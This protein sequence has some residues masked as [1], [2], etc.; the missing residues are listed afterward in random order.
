M[1]STTAYFLEQF[2]DQ[3]D[4]TPSETINMHTIFRELEEWSSMHA[5]LIIAMI[6]A[7]YDC[8]FTGDELAACNTVA[9]IY[10]IVQQKL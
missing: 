4:D 9:D 7:E 8:P 3:F 1:S 6:D 2:R 10:A 5:L